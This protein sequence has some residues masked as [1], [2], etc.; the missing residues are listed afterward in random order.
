MFARARPVAALTGAAPDRPTTTSIVADMRVR[1]GPGLDPAEFRVRFGLI[2]CSPTAAA[3]S[4]FSAR[5]SFSSEHDTFLAHCVREC[6]RLLQHIPRGRQLDSV[7]RRNLIAVAPVRYPAP[8]HTESGPA[9]LRSTGF[10][11]QR[12]GTGHP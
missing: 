4:G 11:G 2:V 3:C 1:I 7:S 8:H 9:A 5:D 12:T 6:S 10:R